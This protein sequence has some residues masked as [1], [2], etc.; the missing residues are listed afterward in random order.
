MEKEIINKVS[1]SG[2]VQIDLEELFPGGDRVLFD[3]KN[4]LFEGLILKEKDFREQLKNHD[5]SFY[6]N[7]FV[8]VTCSAD[9]IIPTWAYMLLAT[10]LDP[11]AKKVVFGDLKKMEQELFHFEILKLNPE[12]YKDQRVVVKGCSNKEVPVSAYMELTALLRPFV[13]SIMYGEPC[14]TVPVYKQPK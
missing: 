1:E 13:K 9:A 6:K 2:L 4:W 3:L 11:F 7:K 14:S 10:Y 5:W 12:Q 8:A